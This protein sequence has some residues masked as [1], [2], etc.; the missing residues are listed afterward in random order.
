MIRPLAVGLLV[1]TGV[2][3]SAASASEPELAAGSLQASDLTRLSQAHVQDGEPLVLV[4]D[5]APAASVVTADA[6]RARAGAFY[7]QSVIRR[8]TGVELPL[9]L[10]RDGQD[11][12]A[13]TPGLHLT[14]DGDATNEAFA[15]ETTDAAVVFRGRTDFA[16]YDWAE[17]VLDVR[18]YWDPQAGGE[19]IPGT[20]GL[21]VPRVAYADRPV[22]A[23][24]VHYPFHDRL[25]AK[26]AKVGASFD[27]GFTVHSTPPGVCYGSPEA[28]ADYVRQIDERIAGVTNGC[29]T[30]DV[31]LKTVSVSPW[32]EPYGCA[33]RWCRTLR[34]HASGVAGDASPIVWGTFL[35]RL[36]HWLA[37]R[38]PDYRIVFLPY[39]N[40]MRLPPRPFGEP[41]RLDNATAFVCNVAGV[42]RLASPEIRAREEA[43]M[44]GW[45][46]ATGRKIVI[47]DYA[48]WP[49]E[50]SVAPYVC[51]RTIRA[52]LDAMRTVTD[53]VF[54]C[55]T[56]ELAR[57]SLL[58]YVWQRCLWNPELDVEAV[59]DEFC[60]RLFGPAAEPM[61][62]V[63][64]LQES[65]WR[66]PRLD[67]APESV[68]ELHRLLLSAQDT[69]DA[70]ASPEGDVRRR[71]F[72]YYA[73]GFS[74]QFAACADRRER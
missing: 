48:C 21:A 32:D 4:R 68:A 69:L 35:P 12:P 56:G 14:D 17:R 20:R 71:R 73:S 44:R 37:E 3:A 62:R 25:W 57:L 67:F 30:V 46:A 11:W 50:E 43:M 60:R 53:G 72:A 8:M 49:A 15:V 58:L 70:D 19:V 66:P 38:H 31:R 29:R 63:V 33:C 39:W 34:S 65:A 54:I 1:W 6:P 23:Y 52:H 24:R 61:R 42:A 51:G 47:W 7:L 26:V 74:R 16:A 22:F 5:G 36:S 40:Y 27:L 45:Q 2:V 18:T 41:L 28:F 55:G 9:V 59:Y 64:A 10:V 13:S